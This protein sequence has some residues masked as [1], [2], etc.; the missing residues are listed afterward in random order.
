M[1]LS[2]TNTVAD[3]PVA[4]MPSGQPRKLLS[5]HAHMKIVLVLLLCAQP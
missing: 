3:K 1:L 4:R 5:Q 2:G